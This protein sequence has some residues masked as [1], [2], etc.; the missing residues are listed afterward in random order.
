ML[1]PFG[2]EP[3]ASAGRARLRLAA[4]RVS[5]FPPGTRMHW[6]QNYGPPDSPVFATLAAA[7]PIVL[8]LGLLA[9]GRVPAA[10][11]ALAGLAAA[12]LAAVFV[13]TPAEAAL[14]GS[15]GLAGWAGTVLAAAGY[16]A[17]FGL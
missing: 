14:P 13:F 12:V 1:A 7:L 16:G 3:E 11:A 4:K 17:A 8:L 10:L 15:V 2:G 6:T 9:T 5:L